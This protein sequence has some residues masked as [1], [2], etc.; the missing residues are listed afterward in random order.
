MFSSGWII[1]V[2]LEANLYGTGAPQLDENNLRLAL[3][4]MKL[5]FLLYFQLHLK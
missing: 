2:L 5:Y 4:G 3:E 1:T